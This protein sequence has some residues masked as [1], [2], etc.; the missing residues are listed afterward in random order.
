MAITVAGLTCS[1]PPSLAAKV[2]TFKVGDRAEIHCALTNGTNT[3]VSVAR[4]NH[5]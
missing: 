1:V 4:L 2:A 5:R 3:L